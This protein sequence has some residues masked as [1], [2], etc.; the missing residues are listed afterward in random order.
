METIMNALQQWVWVS[1][2]VYAVAFLGWL[3]KFLARTLPPV[4]Y[5]N[6]GC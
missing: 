3:V 4:S 5:T 1:I 2:G 6:K